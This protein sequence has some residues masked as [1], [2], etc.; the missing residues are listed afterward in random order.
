MGPDGTTARRRPG[1]LFWASLGWL[2]IVLVGSAMAGH[3]PMPAPDTMHWQRRNAVPGTR[4]DGIVLQRAK[5]AAAHYRFLLGTDTK[6]RDILSRAVHG[7]RVSLTV[8]LLAPAL[9][10]LCGG[11]LGCMAGYCGGRAESFITAAM[12]VILAFP[13][14]VLLLAVSAFWG[15]SL[16]SLVVCLGLLCVPVFCRVARAHTLAIRQR[17]FIQAARLSGAGDL[18]ILLHEVAPNV[19]VPLSTYG[20]MVAAFV[21]MAEGGL[22]FLG[23]GLPAP[24]SSWGVMIADGREVLDQAPH[25]SLIPAAIM[26]L[27]VAAF[28]LIGDSLRNAHPADRGE[29]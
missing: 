15:T 22:S 2:A 14:L 25:V 27:T 23:L 7:A 29:I 3:L 20:L 26:F 18:H 10:L 9:G 4:G 24:R 12:D 6:G 11:L 21:I 8:G 17:E 1:L 28:N 16:T 5:G 13:G 19:I